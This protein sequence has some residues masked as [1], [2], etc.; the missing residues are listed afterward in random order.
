VGK[1]PGVDDGEG[2]GVRV[3]LGDGV[4]EPVGVA[5]GEEV[6]VGD[7]VG[8]GL[9][10]GVGVGVGVPS[11]YETRYVRPVIPALVTPNKRPLSSST[12][13]RKYLNGDV[14]GRVATCVRT[15]S[16]PT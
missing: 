11:A 9:G 8:V 14:F 4:G 10:D 1:I 7:A 16:G 6:G 13:G 5:V 3:G 2:V 12:V 15:P